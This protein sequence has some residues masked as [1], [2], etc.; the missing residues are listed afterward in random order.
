MFRFENPEY[1]YLLITIPILLLL[2]IFVRIQRRY[3]LKKLADIK[4]LPTLIPEV[5][6][7]RPWVK[8]ILCIT[9]LTSLI[10]MVARP[11]VGL[12]LDTD[13]R[14]GIEMIVALDVSNSM[15]ATD[16]SPNRLEKAKML[17]TTISDKLNNN[18]IGLIVFAGDAYVQLPITS[19]G[20]SAQMFLDEISTGMVPTQG[21]NITE[22]LR[23]AKNSFTEQKNVE[24][25]IILITDGEEH[26]G[27]PEDIAADIAKS[28]IHVFVL[29]IGNTK[30]SPIALRGSEYM[31][32]NQ[33]NV[34]ITK[35]NAEMCQKIAIAGKGEYIHVDNSNIAGDRLYYELNK[36]EKTQLSSAVYSEYDEQFMIF[37]IVALLLL[38]IDVC[39]L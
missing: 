18:K 26:E 17:L 22:A 35:L 12:K 19:D 28:G 11:Q 15:L 29:G 20:V 14:N 8:F 4:L 37:A 31:R 32:D 5:S 7:W 21:T 33:G 27:Q 34:V 25:A 38:I 23:L 3:R 39:M 36:L 6:A 30:G 9:V 16:V 1:L 13:K 2:F 10:I 24:R